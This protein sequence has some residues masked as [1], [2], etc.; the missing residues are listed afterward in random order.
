MTNFNEADHYIVIN[1]FL[2]VNQ[3][4]LLL[5]R[6]LAPLV[7]KT[8]GRKH[9]ENTR[10]SHRPNNRPPKRPYFVG[11]SNRTRVASNSKQRSRLAEIEF[12]MLLISLAC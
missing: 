8:G 9:V 2:L 11:I 10:C 1:S 7:T 12:N 3:L 6:V 5:F 4:M